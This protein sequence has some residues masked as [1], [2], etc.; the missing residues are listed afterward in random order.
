MLIR[1]TVWQ[2]GYRGYLDLDLEL[3]ELDEL[4]ESDEEDSELPEP[5]DDFFT[6][7]SSA[8]PPSTSSSSS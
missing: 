1:P 4:E 7:A 3:E 5:R 2:D 6:G 8:L